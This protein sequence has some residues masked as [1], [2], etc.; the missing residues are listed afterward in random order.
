M[1][2]SHFPIFTNNRDL[3]YLDSASTTQKPQSV[4]DAVNFYIT[5]SNS[6]LGRWQYEIALMSESLYQESKTKVAKLINTKANN[7][8]YI[9]GTTYWCNMIAASLVQSNILKP[10]D[11]IMLTVAEHHAN[12]LVRQYLSQT[13]NIQI[14]YIWIDKYGQIDLEDFESKYT[15]DIKIISL[16]TA[17]NVLGII[18][19]MQIKEIKKIISPETILIADASQTLGHVYTDVQDLWID[20]MI[21]WWHKM[22][23]YTGIWCIYMTDKL[24][25]EL[26]PPILGWWIVSDVDFDWYKLYGW[27]DSREAGSPNMIWAISMWA[28]ADFIQ[29]IWW[30][31]AIWAHDQEFVNYRYTNLDNG[32][33][34]ADMLTEYR[35]DIPRLAIFSIKDIYSSGIIW[36]KLME[37]NICIRIGWHCAQ[38]LHGKINDSKPTIRISPYIYNDLSD[39]DKIIDVL[40]KG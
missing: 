26:T 36:L 37:Q 3:V 19:F 25:K 30:Y 14:I 1:L 39:L 8:I 33:I 6:N 34:K 20:I 27:S 11:K 12:M 31:D 38:P 29:S 13:M 22:M 5:H 15:P 21:R 17:S 35:K 9:P 24:L 10:G 18:N 23:A 32:K 4:I 28:A 7:I 2:K 16:S 40:N